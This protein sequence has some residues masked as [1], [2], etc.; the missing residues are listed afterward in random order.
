MRNRKSHSLTLKKKLNKC[1]GVFRAFSEL[2]FKYG[3][4]LESNDEVVEIKSNVVLEDCELGDYTTDFVCVKSNGELRLYPL[5]KNFP[6]PLLVIKNK[7]IIDHLID[8]LENGKKI[9]QYIIVSNH[10]FI[11]HFNEWKKTRSENIIILDD[12]ATSNETRLGAVKDFYFAI[13]KLNINDDTIILAGDNLLEFSLNEFIGFYE[14]KNKSCVMAYYEQEMR[15]LQK[16]GVVEFNSNYKVISMEEKPLEPKSNYVA[17]AFYLYR[18]EDLHLFKKGL[19]S[20]CKIDA[21]GHFLE[22]ASKHTDTY[23]FIMPKNRIDIGTLEDY[24]KAKCM[25]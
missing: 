25:Q 8:D 5:T 21:P 23:V 3:D 14:S 4:E 22:W 10:N 18:K 11:N 19:E 7:P 13:E 16:C 12:G 17:P 20:G 24:N 9:D 2:Q 6:K 15:V 1:K